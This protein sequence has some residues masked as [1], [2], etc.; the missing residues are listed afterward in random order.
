VLRL[1]NDP[2]LGHRLAAAGRADA[3]ARFSVRRMVDQTAAL[4]SSLLT[5]TPI[6]PT[7]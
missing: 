3:L 6:H 7:T 1:L 2:A 5:C 4:Y